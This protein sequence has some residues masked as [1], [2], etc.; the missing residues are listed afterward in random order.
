MRQAFIELAI[1]V[2]T[3]G[4]TQMGHE[5][6]VR[7]IQDFRQFK[8]PGK[9]ALICL[10]RTALDRIFGATRLHSQRQLN[11][12]GGRSIFDLI[13]Q[14]D[15]SMEMAKSLLDGRS[16]CRTLARRRPVFDR[17]LGI[18]GLSPVMSD[19][20]RHLIRNLQVRCTQSFGD[21]LVKLRTRAPQH[22]LIDRIPKQLVSEP[23]PGSVRCADEAGIDELDERL[24][25]IVLSESADALQQVA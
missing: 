22:A 1:Y 24:L 17:P 18:T 11:V 3:I 16:H 5:L 7:T 19:K 2:E 13:K 25:E 21:T 6:L 4:K 23:I 15:G 10:G 14:S 9:M 20:F 8:H 12:G